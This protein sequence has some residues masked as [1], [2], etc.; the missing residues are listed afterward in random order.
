[1]RVC[2]VGWQCET[3]G[4]GRELQVQRRR[5][6]RPRRGAGCA[7]CGE[8]TV[9]GGWGEGCELCAWCYDNIPGVTE[10]QCLTAL[11]LLSWMVADLWGERRMRESVTTKAGWQAVV[12]WI[13]QEREAQARDRVL[14]AHRQA[15]EQELE[16]KVQRHE[17]WGTKEGGALVA[18]ESFM[19]QI[20]QEVVEKAA[21]EAEK[22]WAGDGLG[23]ANDRGEEEQVA[24]KWRRLAVEVL[25][26]V[27]ELE[28]W[29]WP[30]EGEA[31]TQEGVWYGLWVQTDPQIRSMMEGLWEGE[32]VF[33]P[34]VGALQCLRRALRRWERGSGPKVK[35]WEWY[36]E[37][38][39]GGR[40]G[41]SGV[42]EGEKERIVGRLDR[43]RRR[44]REERERQAHA[45]GQAL[46]RAK[47]P[48]RQPVLRTEE[49]REKVGGSMLDRALAQPCE[50]VCEWKAGTGRRA[51]WAER[52]RYMAGMTISAV[53]A[54]GRGDWLRQGVRVGCIVVRR[55]Q[56]E[57][58]QA[59][60]AQGA[61]QDAEG[62]S[63]QGGAGGASGEGSVGS[64]RDLLEDEPAAR[65]VRPLEA[66]VSGQ[67]QAG[68]DRT[69]EGWGSA[70]W[71]DTD[72]Q[73]LA[74]YEEQGGAECL[75]SIE[76]AIRQWLQ[77][78]ASAVQRGEAGAGG[79]E[80]A[81][82]QERERARKEEG[83][84]GESGG[85]RRGDRRGRGEHEEQWQCRLH[86]TERACELAAERGQGCLW[87]WRRVGAAEQGTQ[88][89]QEVARAEGLRV[90]LNQGWSGRGGARGGHGRGRVRGGHTQGR[91]RKVRGVRRTEAGSDA[92]MERQEPAT[93][94]VLEEQA[95]GGVGR[96][97]GVSA[98]ATRERAAIVVR[99]APSAVS[100]PM[101]GGG[102]R[103]K[104]TVE[105]EPVVP[106][107]TRCT[108][109]NTM[110]QKRSESEAG[111]GPSRSGRQRRGTRSSQEFS[112]A[113]G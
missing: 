7:Y 102:G 100:V 18:V 107:L 90:H 89:E 66:G 29:P 74:M 67:S 5:R 62:G 28:H 87:E 12:R 61:E 92:A 93:R 8:T 39:W 72:P 56:V 22:R 33:R 69:S 17:V 111:L 76:Q 106:S 27:P 23:G 43:A 88:M 9:G 108:R 51:L 97:S 24:A 20:V 2:V 99:A 110:Q 41:R 70:L 25:G 71:A 16:W 85:G 31:P 1:M 95:D 13:G 48:K 34:G 30:E 105:A 103:S 19:Q 59:R 104:P 113:A 53:A 60:D 79:V 35:E 26:E 75:P 38:Q 54:G 73:F 68:R 112:N 15:R 32:R 57:G 83:R 52:C 86:G 98:R 14:A 82:V 47:N 11:L 37:R 109:A 78:T 21:G 58:V 45:S 10:V 94:D 44:L 63:Q 50:W 36:E 4:E 55:R 42:T 6:I 84:Q 3:T 101:E 81:L 65:D 64:G 46:S 49:R 40:E 91:D 77:A 80:G 96:N